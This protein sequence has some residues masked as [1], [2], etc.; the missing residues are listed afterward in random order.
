MAPFIEYDR[1]NES[2]ARGVKRLMG[3]RDGEEALRGN[4][5]SLGEKIRDVLSLRNFSC[6]SVGVRCRDV[7]DGL[8]ATDIIKVHDKLRAGRRIQPTDPEEEQC[9]RFV[10]DGV[11]ELVGRCDRTR[12][13]KFID[14]FMSG[15]RWSYLCLVLGFL[16]V[17]RAFVSRQACAEIPH[18]KMKLRDRYVQTNLFSF[19]KTMVGKNDVI[20][21]NLKRE[22]A[23]DGKAPRVT[24]DYK[25]GCMYANELPEYVKVCLDGEEVYQLG[26]YTLVVFIVAKPKS[27]SLEKAFSRLDTYWR[28]SRIIYAVVYS[29]D[30]CISGLGEAY[31]VDI[32]SCD[33][34]Q[35]VSA[36]L[37][38]Y[39][40]MR[41]FH[42]E[43][44]EGLIDQC[45]L[46]MDIIGADGKSRMRIKFKGPFLGSGTVLTTPLNHFASVMI[47]LGSLYWVNSGMTLED[48]VRRGAASVGHKV[49]V[50]VV[51]FL[52]DFQFLKRSCTKISTSPDCHGNVQY[53]YVVFTNR[54]CMLR[55]LGKIWNVIEPRH[56]GM[57]APE[58]NLLTIAERADKF[59][60]A[61]I[62][63]WKLEP[64]CPIID[65]L[66]RRFSSEVIPGFEVI[67]DSNKFV[68][69]ESN[70]YSGYSVGEAVVT[71]YR[72]S[73]A[74]LDELVAKIDRIQ[75]GN[76][77]VAQAL[78]NIYSKDYGVS[79]YSWDEQELGLV[80]TS[81]ERE[82]RIV[83]HE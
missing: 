17:F 71:R 61:V 34:G 83:W 19:G 25:A 48:A 21:I 69:S 24:A 45:M 49:T 11:V 32:S 44:S 75:L 58:F 36:F 68:F 47:A 33:T 50:E 59:F 53:K 13:Q 38:M 63:G 37:A 73:S 10:A 57:S 41:R 62:A 22:T 29:D 72:L 42:R 15:A 3:S 79:P 74:A 76:Q 35:D 77:C 65:A 55:N 54:A 8:W 64:S 26:E 67:P 56:V 78:E 51:E 31:N 20:S 80:E 30:M 39:A 27:D 6:I 66:R 18:L 4:N 2:L 81:L 1:S 16:T 60:S 23:K 46:P 82:E 5:L 14:A 40:S 52:E 9:Q 12:L 43:H 28:S 70:D 7:M